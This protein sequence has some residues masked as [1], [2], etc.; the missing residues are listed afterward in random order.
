MHALFTV[1]SSRACL[2][3]TWQQPAL[4]L[5]GDQGRS[6]VFTSMQLELPFVL[7]LN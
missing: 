6:N 7:D 4:A 5:G 3:E 2:L 1:T